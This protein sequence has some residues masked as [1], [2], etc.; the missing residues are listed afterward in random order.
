MCQR[1]QLEDLAQKFEGM[2]HIQGWKSQVHDP[3]FLRHQ[4]AICL[5]AWKI[6]NKCVQPRTD[7]DQT[8][9]FLSEEDKASPQSWVQQEHC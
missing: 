1:G 3:T 7:H 6:A 8:N 5:A 2:N 9:F 4:N